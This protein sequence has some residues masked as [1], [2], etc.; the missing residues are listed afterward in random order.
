VVSGG[1]SCSV[2]LPPKLT[3]PLDPVRV[4]WL[5]NEDEESPSESH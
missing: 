5:S 1:A 2:P 3:K 4:E